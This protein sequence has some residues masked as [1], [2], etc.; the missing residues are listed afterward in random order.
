MKYFIYVVH[1]VNIVFLGMNA[2]LYVTQ[3]LKLNTLVWIQGIMMICGLLF[4]WCLIV[5]LLKKDRQ[6]QRTQ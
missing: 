4:Q 1:A 3:C 5:Y 2:Y 6:R